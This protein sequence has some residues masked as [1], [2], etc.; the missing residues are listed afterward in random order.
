MNMGRRIQGVTMDFW[1]TLVLDGPAA[2]ERYRTLRL[3]GVQTALAHT[4]FTVAWAE[5]ERAYDLSAVYLGRLWRDG[6]DASVSQHVRVLLEG[7]DPALPDRLPPGL[8]RHLI[9][10]YASPLLLAPPTFDPGAGAALE[11]L[12]AG[13]LRIGVVSNTARTPGDTLRTLLGRHG[14]LEHF[15]TTTF[16]DECGIR[17]PRPEI[18]ELTLQRLG[19]TAG[20]VIHVGD[21]PVLDVRGARGARMRVIQV[22]PDGRPTRRVKPD[23]AIAMLSELPEAVE[24]LMG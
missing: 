22:T 15:T 3:D 20:E 5:L 6:R 17:K 2:D 21:D 23:L 1:G 14:L 24:R 8:M 16:S 9:H 11:Q 12:A 4:G 7:I 10:A 18:F 13:G 19:V